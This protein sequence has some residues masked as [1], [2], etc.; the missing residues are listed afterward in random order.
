MGLQ[1]VIFVSVCEAELQGGFQFARS[2]ALNATDPQ[3]DLQMVVSVAQSPWIQKNSCDTFKLCYLQG[4]RQA[5]DQLLSF[6]VC[7]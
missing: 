4:S 1:T 5:G 7:S 3:G 6:L 2:V